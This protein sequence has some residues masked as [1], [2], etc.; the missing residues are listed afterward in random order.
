M[1]AWCDKETAIAC[2]DT[3]LGVAGLSRADVTAI[4]AGAAASD[5]LTGSL[6]RYG[7]DAGTESLVRQRLGSLR[8]PFRQQVRIPGVGRVDFGLVG[9]KIV[10]EVDSWRHHGDRDGFERDR[11]R[12]AELVAR[13]YTVIRLTYLRVMTDWAWCERMILAALAAQG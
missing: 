7:S 11:R 5:R 10:V 8:I 3:A 2:L 6:C 9:T 1:V 12:D 4:F 13:G